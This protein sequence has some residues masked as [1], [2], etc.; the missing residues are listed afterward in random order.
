M[1][2][3]CMNETMIT[4]R[5]FDKNNAEDVKLMTDI[6]SAIKNNTILEFFSPLPLT[7]LF[8]AYSKWGTKSFSLTE[9]SV[10]D[11]ANQSPTDGCFY[12][13]YETANTPATPAFMKAVE[14]FPRLE[15]QSRYTE[16]NQAFAG[17]VT[18]HRD[19]LVTTHIDLSTWIEKI[20]EEENISEDEINENQD[21][22]YSKYIESLD[23]SWQLKDFLLANSFVF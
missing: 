8:D 12:F 20:Q 5:D 1:A 10:I 14:R 2:N 17:E 4:L 13:V 7:Q 15:I 9:Q 21:F 19:A 3:T 22:Y 6:F 18:I 16:Y 23:C 11:L